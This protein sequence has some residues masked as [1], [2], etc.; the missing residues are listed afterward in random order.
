MLSLFFLS[1][2]VFLISFSIS[3]C[4]CHTLFSLWEIPARTSKHSQQQTEHKQIV[5]LL[6]LGRNI[7][8]EVACLKKILGVKTCYSR[9]AC[10]SSVVLDRRGSTVT[11]TYR[12]LYSVWIILTPGKNAINDIIE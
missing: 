2:S 12:Y 5:C 7:V 6:V 3:E 8:F 4:S 11:T 1:A 10:S 9:Y